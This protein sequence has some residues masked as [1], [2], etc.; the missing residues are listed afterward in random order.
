MNKTYTKPI[1]GEYIEADRQSQQVKGEIQP[2]NRNSAG[3]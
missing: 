1:T 2:A 3:R